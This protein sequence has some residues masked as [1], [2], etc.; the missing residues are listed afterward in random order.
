MNRVRA[1][2]AYI[3]I[4]S[5]ILLTGTM[6]LLPFISSKE[7]GLNDYADFFAKIASAYTGI[8]GVIVGYYFGRSDCK[9]QC[10]EESEQQTQRQVDRRRE[11][12]S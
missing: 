12:E 3:F 2:I 7:T 8:I 10:Q 6:A 4:I 5:F 11:A 9:C 1:N